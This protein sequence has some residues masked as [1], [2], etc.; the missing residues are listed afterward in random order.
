VVNPVYVTGG[1]TVQST[2][3]ADARVEY[4][5]N[6]YIDETQRMGWMQRFFTNVLPF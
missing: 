1:N 3:V 6:G 2:Q 4:K 5:A